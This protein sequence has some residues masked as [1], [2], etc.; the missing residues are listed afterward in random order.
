MPPFIML[1]GTVCV[2][3]SL[4]ALL[5]ESPSFACVCEA[6]ISGREG[7]DNK[8]C[9]SKG[10]MNHDFSFYVMVSFDY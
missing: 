8:D 5:V 10:G 4:V 6:S 7:K 1:I 2:E 9:S 3:P